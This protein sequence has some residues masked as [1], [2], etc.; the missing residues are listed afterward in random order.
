MATERT[1]A[2]RHLDLREIDGEP[3]GDNTAE[4]ETFSDDETLLL[5]NSLSRNRC[6]RS[7]KTVVS[8]TRRRP[9]RPTSNILKSD[10]INIFSR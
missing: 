8:S 3:F 6:I 4:L 2:N 9:T 10:I 1:E 7:S 5:I